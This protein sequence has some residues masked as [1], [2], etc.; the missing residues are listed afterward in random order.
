MGKTE[1][2]QNKKKIKM[3]GPSDSK[4]DSKRVWEK[5]I[6]NHSSCPS[7]NCLTT[8]LLLLQ[9]NYF[10][11]INLRLDQEKRQ[12]V[13]GFV[14]IIHKLEITQSLIS[15]QDRKQLLVHNEK[16]TQPNCYTQFGF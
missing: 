4:R 6:S 2:K 15:H 9:N 16:K 14:N 7:M 13:R 11:L 10:L 12:H 1:G 3:Q 5:Q 8:K